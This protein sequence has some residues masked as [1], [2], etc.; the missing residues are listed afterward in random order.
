MKKILIAAICVLAVLIGIIA[1][2]AILSEKSDGTVPSVSYYT[3][4]DVR[5]TTVVEIPTKDPNAQVQFSMPLHYLEDKYKNDLNLFC[6]E[7]NYIACTIDE[8]A[9]TFTVTMNAM[10][11]DLMLSKVGIQSIKNIANVMNSEKYPFFKELGNSVKISESGFKEISVFVDR[12]GYEAES[13]KESF[14]AYIAGCGIY[15]QLYTT[16]N[17]YSCKVIVQ[18]ME[19]DEVLDAKLFQQNNSGV[20]S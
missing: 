19:S 11:H 14:M 8:Q 6:Q 1:V 20:I 17:D 5:Q 4:G 9:Q 3:D 7:N 13:D 10:T 16:S 12:A 2:D 18:D 15:Y